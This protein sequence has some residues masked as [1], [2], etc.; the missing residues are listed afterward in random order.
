MTSENHTKSEKNIVIPNRNTI[1]SLPI[2]EF[3]FDMFVNDPAIVVIAKRGSGKSCVIREIMTH[4]SDIPVGNVISMSENNDPFYGTF[5]PD[6]Y[7]FNEYKTEILEKLLHRQRLIKEKASEKIK[8]KKKIDTRC[9]LIMDDCLASRG[10]W[11]KDDTLKNVL[12]NGRHDNIMYILAMQYPLG[13]SPE[14]RGNFDY[15]FLLAEDYVSQMKRIYEHY[16]GMFPSFD[17]FRQVFGQ[18][19]V[20]YGCMVIV[21]RGV[22]SSFL[23]KIY[24]YRAPKTYVPKPFGHKQFR[25]FHEKNY[26][27]SWRRNVDFDADEYMMRKKKDKSKI[28]IKRVKEDER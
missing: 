9:Y 27:P 2:Q 16:A 18:L 6:T 22:R 14:L 8:Q 15:I 12:F 28:A 21:N 19:T 13:I 25:K 11:N 4:Y 5:F 10:T 1:N 20:D 17:S 3:T 7:V 24:W 26:N 23:E